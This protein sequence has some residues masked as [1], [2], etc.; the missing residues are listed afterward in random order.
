MPA[1]SSGSL[2]GPALTGG[3]RRRSSQEDVYDPG[4]DHMRSRAPPQAA[5]SATNRAQSGIASPPRTVSPDRMGSRAGGSFVSRPSSPDRQYDDG[6]GYKLRKFRRAHIEVADCIGKGAYGTV[7][8]ASLVDSNQTVV[9]KVLWPDEDLNPDD[10]AEN[11]GPIKERMEAFQR[12]I[13]MMELSGRHPNIVTILGATKD[14][15]VIVFEQALTDLQ[16]LTKKQRPCDQNS[17]SGLTLPYITKWTYEILAAVEYLHSVQIVHRDL[18]PANILIFQDMTA[19]VGDFGMARDFSRNSRMAVGREICT[20]WYRAPELLMGTHSYNA[21]VDEWAVGCLALEMLC[22]QNAMP[23]RV[24]QVCCCSEVSHHNYNSDQL[25]LIFMLLGTPQ[26]PAFLQKFSCFTHFGDWETHEPS[27]CEFLEEVGIFNNSA[28]EAASLDLSGIMPGL[29]VDDHAGMP[30]DD[31]P[32][33]SFLLWKY[34][35]EKLLCID[36]ENR[37]SASEVLD[38]EVFAVPRKW[39]RARD[40]F[41]GGAGGNTPQRPTSHKLSSGISSGMRTDYICVYCACSV[42][43]LYMVCYIIHIIHILYMRHTFGV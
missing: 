3:T 41:R 27:L 1:S 23:G 30:P 25:L 15:R 12:E 32:R 17:F 7:W 18:K 21:K 38:M 35:L 11:G 22:G 10:V 5:S 39:L 34:A 9:V 36:P 33:A 29:V 42:I 24:E 2:A 28:A 19:K 43:L 20:L 37:A 8:Q 14:S 40:G 31:T 16:A 26:N 4:D 13:E 6:N